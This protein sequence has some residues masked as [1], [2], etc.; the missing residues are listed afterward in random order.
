[1]DPTT[2]RS[3]LTSL[4]KSRQNP[5]AITKLV[6]NTASMGGM[7]P[8][9]ANPRG[10]GDGSSGT[11]QPPSSREGASRTRPTSSTMRPPSSSMQPPSSSMQPPSRSRPPDA[12]G[13][14]STAHDNL[15]PPNSQHTSNRQ[16]NRVQ[17]VSRPSD[18]TSGAPPLQKKYSEPSWSAGPE[19]DFHLEVLKS[20][21]IIDDIPLKSNF[22]I[23]GRHPAVHLT[24]EN[25]S[26]SRQ[27]AVFQ[28]SNDGCCYLFDLGSTHGTMVNKQS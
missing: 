20:G 8:P 3:H 11:M 4:S 2:R 25:P 5:A 19:H 9:T 21:A 10:R 24:M 16:G 12:M 23:V 7:G 27:H 28:F 22:L 1:M 26:V 13:A 18:D 6:R 17:A 15:A 14:P